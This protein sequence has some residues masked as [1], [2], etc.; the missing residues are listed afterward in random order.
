MKKHTIQKQFRMT[1][2]DADLLKTKATL[3]GLSQSSLVRT[4]IRGYAP[5]EKPPPEFYADMRK[6]TSIA[7]NLNQLAR[8]ANT[9]GY[10][11]PDWLKSESLKWGELF[12]H[13][14]RRW[15][16]PDKIGG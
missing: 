5:R 15:T 1:P 10:I 12:L 2:E 14:K 11:D 6:L 4:L 13:L 7:N 8:I 16:L 3:V 9:D